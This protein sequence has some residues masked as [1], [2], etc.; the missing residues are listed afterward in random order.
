M[1]VTICNCCHRVC[2]VTTEMMFHTYRLGPL[3][4]EV[5]C[6]RAVDICDDCYYGLGYL[7]EGGD[8]KKLIDKAKKRRRKR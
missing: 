6:E 8:L 7:A 2:D 5:V 3:R 4:D 1:K